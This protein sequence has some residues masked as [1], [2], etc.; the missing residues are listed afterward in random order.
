[1][2]RNKKAMSSF[3]ETRTYC[4]LLAVL[5]GFLAIMGCLFI[6]SIIISKID[7]PSILVTVMSTIALGIG[8]YS[9]GFVCAK[10]RRKNGMFMGLV[11]GAIIFF[12]IFILS[13]IVVRT[14]INFTF[15]TKLILAIVC[16]AIGGVVGVNSKSRKF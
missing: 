5:I 11:T 15:A 6:F 16:G 7:A 13:V 14:A 9:G 8:A 12:L 3:K 4:T 1:M 2:S 10:K